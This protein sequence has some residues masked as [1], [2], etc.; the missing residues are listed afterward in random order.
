MTPHEKVTAVSL[1]L[2]SVM[3]VQSF[4]GEDEGFCGKD[5]GFCGEDEG[6]F[7]KMKDFLL[8]LHLCPKSFIFATL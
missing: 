8:F 3:S 6:F 7:A 1:C 4:F 2:C 5:E